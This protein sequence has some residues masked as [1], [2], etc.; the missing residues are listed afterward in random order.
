MRFG[1]LLRLRQGAV[2]AERLAD[3][4]DR[5]V[6]RHRDRAQASDRLAQHV[7]CPQAARDATAAD[8]AERLA[9]PRLERHVEQVLQ[10]PWEAVVVLRRHDDEAVRGVQLVDERAQVV[11]DGD[12]RRRRAGVEVGQ[13]DP[14][15]A[16]RH[17]H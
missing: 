14:K 10:R 3:V 2:G 8:K 15:A 12:A 7:K 17:Q 1:P 9:V 4:G 5:D 6:L 11:G 13:V 16:Q